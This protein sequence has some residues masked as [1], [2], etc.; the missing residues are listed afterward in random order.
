[1]TPRKESGALPNRSATSGLIYRQVND[2][3]RQVRIPSLSLEGLGSKVINIPA[4]SADSLRTIAQA[5]RVITSA[6]SLRQS[7]DAQLRDLNPAPRI[8][9][10]RVM[11]ERLKTADPK[12]LGMAGTAKLLADARNTLNELTGTLGKVK[13]LETAVSSGVAGVKADVAGLDEA[14]RADYAYARSLV[15]L[16]S[17]DAPDISPALFGQIGMEKLKPVL[18]WLKIAEKYLPPGLNPRTRLGP[19]RARA[20]GVDVDFPREQSYPKFLLRFA[21]IDVSLGGQNLAAGSYRAQA[22]GFTTEPTLYGRPMQLVLRRS[23]GQAGPRNARVFLQMDHA[24]APLRDSAVASL[25]GFSLPTISLSQLGA[26]LALGEGLTELTVSR[27]GPNVAGRW[28]VQAA[29]A[30]WQ[31]TS[32]A[33]ATGKVGALVED[34]IW[35]TVSSIRNVEIEAGING[36]LDHPAL[37]V[38]SNVGD[39]VAAGLKKA[40]G[41]EI[42]RAETMIRAKVDSLEA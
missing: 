39:A 34:L 13:A 9:S 20:S 28:R 32:M 4:I 27:A 36:T 40:V 30:S 33:G 10:A 1:G 41:Q 12:V 17:L 35:R 11:V 14:R 6:D 24:K 38:R 23:G 22:V 5:R 2:W 19:K 29:N 18:Y 37:S 31:K 42:A 25:G 15:H 21:D 8:D 16:P 7:W 26:S 3:A